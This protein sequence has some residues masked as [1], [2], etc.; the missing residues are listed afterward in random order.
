MTFIRR[1]INRSDNSSILIGD[2]H[3]APQSQNG[4]FGWLLLAI[5]AIMTQSG[6]LLVF[7]HAL[8]FNAS[9]PQILL[10]TLLCLVFSFCMSK[11]CKRTLQ[12]VVLA[13]SSLA[14]IML[15]LL[16]AQAVSQGFERLTL[17]FAAL[18]G[19][20][21]RIESL[22]KITVPQTDAY[23]SAMAVCICF[24][25][26]IVCFST[27]K[28]HGYG[29]LLLC[30]APT[31][32]AAYLSNRLSSI[33]AVLIFT[34]AL[35]YYVFVSVGRYSSDGTKTSFASIIK[36]RAAVTASAIVLAFVTLLT[37]V[38]APFVNPLKYTL[39]TKVF[40]VRDAI[41][42]Y[43]FDTTGISL[44]GETVQSQSFSDGKLRRVDSRVVKGERQLLIEAQNIGAVYLKCY[45]GC[46][47]DGGMWNDVPAAEYAAL[48]QS[49]E[50]SSVGVSM[51]WQAQYDNLAQRGLMI[52]RQLTITDIQSDS[53]Y[54]FMPYFVSGAM[55]GDGNGIAV[56]ADCDGVRG[57]SNKFV[58]TYYSLA[59]N[60]FSYTYCNTLLQSFESPYAAANNVYTDF[61][62][63]HYLS[64]PNSCGRIAAD[65]GVYSALTID[66]KLSLVYKYLSE[67]TSYSLNVQRIPVG[68]D[69]AEYFIYQSKQGYCV[70]YAT[71]AAV[72]LRA[73]GVPTRFAEGY[74]ISS[75]TAKRL[76][77]GQL[78]LTDA[79][80]HAWVEVYYDNLGW[81]PVEFTKGRGLNSGT[82]P[83]PVQTEEATP[84]PTAQST[85]V[86]SAAAPTYSAAP[87]PTPTAASSRQPHSTPQPSNAAPTAAATPNANA[88][89]APAPSKAQAKTLW[90]LLTQKDNGEPASAWIVAL[91]LLPLVLLLLIGL[92]AL[93]RLVLR[94]VRTHRFENKNPNAAINNYTH[95]IRMLSRTGVSCNEFT[96][97]NE[98]ADAVVG[99][100]YEE[101]H[102]TLGAACACVYV[103]RFSAQSPTTAEL[104]KLRCAVSNVSQLYYQEL[105]FIG[106]AV[107]ILNGF[108]RPKA[109]R[110][111]KN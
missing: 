12:I 24:F 3:I 79:D 45:T 101:L 13:M 23:L 16:E 68:A 80:R 97:P 15:V 63:Q 66:E 37:F 105:S 26:F 57:G 2:A 9:M 6:I 93:R 42:D 34:A 46:V 61:V 43:F 40:S 107:L 38:S 22:A 100:A 53:D 36:N 88:T 59:R 81:L 83:L 50:F 104:N 73:M 14:V 69:F 33:G 4:R 5:T 111:V 92:L 87:V 109:T 90:Q 110:K 47:Y 75:V 51:L 55:D 1:N 86:S 27:F 94:R 60:N 28:R 65:F 30:L 11:R 72:M 19:R 76:T 99:T 77:D 56:L 48:W 8:D 10:S 17:S 95:M 49:S 89:N 85:A 54:C 70:H 91:R 41:S 96:T 78:Y 102:G 98:L 20:V 21:C 103:Q 7:A 25:S 108:S 82:P 31:I 84:A 64:L 35:T 52:R 106:K 39:D 62:Y 58:Y 18:V 74:Y 44:F 29:L 67:S 71:A 32:A